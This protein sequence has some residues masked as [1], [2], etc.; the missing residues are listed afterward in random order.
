MVEYN[1]ESAVT[2][3]CRVGHRDRTSACLMS[4]VANVKYCII[5]E[6]RRSS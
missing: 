1:V 3:T 2:V 5:S 4:C 6:D